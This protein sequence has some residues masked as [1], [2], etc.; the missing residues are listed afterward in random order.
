VIV[1][2]VDKY[3]GNRELGNRRQTS[4]SLSID[5]LAELTGPVEG[6]EE[7]NDRVSPNRLFD[8]LHP[9]TASQEFLQPTGSMRQSKK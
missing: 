7:A 4:R 3:F 5:F 9:R 8:P 6:V 2:R 1:L